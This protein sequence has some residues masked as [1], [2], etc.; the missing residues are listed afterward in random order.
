MSNYNFNTIGYNDNLYFPR[1]TTKYLV[2]GTQASSTNVWVG[3]L[4]EGIS[5]YED[6]L[7][8]DYFLPYE[9]NTSAA[10]LNLGGL[11]AKPVYLGNSNTPVTNQFPQYSVIRLTYL[12][13]AGLNSSNGCWKVSAYYDTNSGGT[14]TTVSAGVGLAGGNITTSGT[15]KAN[16]R[17]EVPLPLAS[18]AGITTNG[19]VYPIVL[20]S[21][22]YLSVN[23]PWTNINNNYITQHQ[24]IKQDGVTGATGSHFANCTTA[25]TA[26][27]KTASILSGTPTLETGLR[28]IVKFAN[29]NSAP[30]PTLNV[31]GTGAKNIYHNGV[32][33]TTGD[34]I[35]LLSGTVEFVYD[36][37]QWQFVGNFI[38]REVLSVALYNKLGGV[39]PWKSHTSPSSGPTAATD[40][41]AVTVNNYSTTSGRYYAV[42]MD[43][44]GR[45]FINV[46][47]TNTWQPLTFT[48]PGYIN[49]A[50]NTDHRVWSR[51]GT[52]GWHDPNLLYLDNTTDLG[53]MNSITNLGWQDDCIIL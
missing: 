13:V 53:L 32:Q 37:V 42:E 1:D 20:D 16:L 36:G 7:T 24:V 11:G 10:T 45:M 26:A 23:V 39:Q 40:S 3:N 43:N 19:R 15:I 48:Q 18:S 29:T 4:P 52:L 22:G 50:A 25:A 35:A 17:D 33:I 44:N 9:G 12:V 47:W 27:A 38:N 2:R 51:E 5:A 28:V 21:D 6:G 41:T 14:V 46:P 8:I 34:T 30:N 31:N 49:A